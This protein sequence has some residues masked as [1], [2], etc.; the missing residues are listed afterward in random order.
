MCSTGRM[1]G[2][3]ARA[4]RRRRDPRRGQLLPDAVV[5]RQR[6]DGELGAR[7]STPARPWRCAASSRRRDSST[8]CARFGATYFTYVGRALAYVLAQPPTPYD[9]DNRLRLGFGTEASGL[10]RQRFT[11]RY[12]CPLVESYGSSESVISIMRTPDT[13]T[14]ALGLPRDTPGSDVAVV[15]QA[16]G[17]ECPRGR[18]DDAGVLRERRATPSARSW[19]G[20]GAGTFEGYYNNAEATPERMRDGWYWTRRSRL[21]RRSRL[22]LLRRP[23]RR[24]AAGRQRELRRRTGRAHPPAPARRGDGCRLSGAR[25]PHG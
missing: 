2:A 6:A 5:P 20:G 13:P 10:D 1:A 14:H 9:R 17:D 19:S 25:S 15:D 4:A 11:E 3:G 12:G 7:R 23:Q 22:L 21:P 8:T 18:F 16:T 24:L